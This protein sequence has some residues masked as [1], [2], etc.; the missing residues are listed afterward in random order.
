MNS[1]LKHILLVIWSLML[2]TTLEAQ[3]QQKVTLQLKWK[4]Q[5][6]FAGYY[7]AIEKGFY[8]EAGLEVKL[9]EAIEGINPSEIVFE[10]KA[11]FGVCSSDILLMRA[12]NK[13]AVVLATIFQHS[14]QILLAAKKSGIENV[15]NLIGKRLAIEPNAADIIALMTDE[16]VTLDKCSVDQ[17]QFNADKLIRGEIDAITAYSTDEV[18]ELKDANFEYVQLS[19]NMDGIDFYGD[20]L[21][22]TE[23]FIQKNPAL[24]EKFRKASLKGWKYA[25]KNQE[26]IIQLIYNKYSK[27]HSVE[28]L[29]FEAN[30]MNKLIM[31]DVIEIGYTN[32]AR[33]ES[34]ANIYKKLN[35]LNSSFTTDGLL[36]SDYQKNNVEIPWKV[37]IGFLLI[38]A[39]IALIAYFFYINSQ[40][41]KKEIA[42]RILL[43]NDLK[44]SEKK[45]RFLT[46]FTADVIWVLNITTGK[47]T[48]ISPSV[49]QLRGF[50]VEEAM[51]ETLENA[52]T[53]ESIVIVNDAISKNIQTFITQPDL[54]NHYLNEIQQYCKNGEIIW[55]EV[56]TQ[57]RYCPTGDIE[58]IGVSRNIEERKKAEAKI[59]ESETELRKLNATKDKFFSIIA[60]DLKSPFN[61]IIGFSEALIE[62]VIDKDY[63]GIRKYADII[64]QSSQKAMN[65]LMNLMEWAQ[66]QTGRI[67]FMPE[68]FI[69]NDLI[70][71]NVNLFN[72]IA[73]QK[74]INIKTE[75]FANYNVTADKAMIKTV[76]RN[77]ISNAVKFTKQ[78]GEISISTVLSQ[79]KVIVSVKDNGIGIPTENIEKLFRIDESYSTYGTNKESGTGLGLILCKEFIEKHNEKIWVESQLSIGTCFYF[80]LSLNTEY[81]EK[82]M[83]QNA[84]SI[85]KTQI[86]TKNLKILIAEDDEISEL[87]ITTII[88]NI[89][90]EI[91][92]ARN[93]IEA[94]EICRNYPDIDLILM[95]I[96]MP[97]I[98]GYEATRQI[99]QFN[100]NVIIIAQTAF[101]LTGDREKAIEAGCN[102]YI[103]KPI[104]KDKLMEMI[105]TYFKS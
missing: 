9:N 80:T 103:T 41:F 88:K 23:A 5:F 19:P 66:S 81:E 59:L 69:I 64:N 30:A 87:F 73:G 29:R 51:L 40:R 28:H 43:E 27:R 35:M 3:N 86:Q 46:E 21:F 26:E 47:F 31:A 53:P 24:V 74:S 44:E 22:T 72:E 60:H 39:F 12:Q 14:P 105:D 36:Y 71:E 57:F 11:E 102:D 54:P 55:V 100:K 38:I 20:V 7:S 63:Q 33:W 76:L 68:S 34:I 42:Q 94:I 79:N 52:I 49:F 89:S 82:T 65:L 92:K 58:I 90:K 91:L 85:E 4:H 15:H 13:K 95:D 45:Y 70:D 48:Y 10:G 61:S 93:G 97:E 62:Q 56:S 75:L 77:L 2:G 8:K 16:G 25:M 37:I 98:S 96:K 101:G 104:N 78:G 83:E 50:N 32:P 6:Q 99:R 1:L 17:H 18:Y 84:F 67:E